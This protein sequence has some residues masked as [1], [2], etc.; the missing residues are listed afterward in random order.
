M[1]KHKANKDLKLEFIEIREMT[2]A[3]VDSIVQFYFHS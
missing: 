3:E 2:E 1:R